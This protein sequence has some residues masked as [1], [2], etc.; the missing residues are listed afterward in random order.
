MKQERFWQAVSGR[1][2]SFDGK[3]VYAVRS[4]GVYCRP[5]CPS[6]RPRRE[7]V[8]F[9][10]APD[11]AEQ[12]GFR[13]CRRCHPKRKG[14]H[15]DQEL[16]R[17][18]CGVLEEGAG[19]AGA[20][21]QLKV[22]EG[23]LRAAFRRTLGIT[24]REYGDE[25]K[26]AAFKSQVREGRGVTDALYEAGYG[27]SSRLYER[28]SS[29]LGM[30]PGVYQKGGRGMSIAYTMVECPLGRLLVGRTERGICAVSLGAT[31]AELE[32]ALEEQYP[33]ADRR[34]D[35]DA[36]REWI[37]AIVNHLAGK[38]PSL[39]LPL[40][41]RATSFQRRVWDEL[42]KIPY[43][44]T[45]SYGEVATAIGEPG[46]AR[47]VARACAT[48]PAALVIPCHRVVRNDGARGGY[49]WGALRKE[50]LLAKEA[51]CT[52]ANFN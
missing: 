4:T 42:K 52:R 27:S 40:D 26:L 44:S 28:A 14:A 30:T 15:P 18:A 41:L 5:S 2:A 35:S 39:D 6:R 9:F 45:R 19:V 46:S 37:G 38:Q 47:A 13:A 21:R 50:K 16:I 10:V 51:E 33:A 31:D 11:A 48:N 8:V 22:T 20:A 49:R 34:R 17:R 25:R 43:G 7:Q 23:R 32:A 36:A 24:P 12:A 1:D 29:R 3:F